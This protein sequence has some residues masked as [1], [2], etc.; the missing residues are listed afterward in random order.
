VLVEHQHALLA[1]EQ[2][3]PGGPAQGNWFTEYISGGFGSNYL[4][5]GGW[6]SSQ[7]YY[8]LYGPYPTPQTAALFGATNSPYDPFTTQML[9]FSGAGATNQTT[10]LSALQYGGQFAN[11]N[12]T[13]LAPFLGL[14]L[15][16]LQRLGIGTLG[17]NAY[18]IAGQNFPFATPNDPNVLTLAALFGGNVPPGFYLPT[19]GA[20]FG[21]GLGQ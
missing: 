5:P 20:Q 13:G 8:G 2:L 6:R 21:S 15:N 4:G 12:R 7:P 18:S 17:P 14:N 10:G 11:L 1:G 3:A 9:A 19:T 16:T